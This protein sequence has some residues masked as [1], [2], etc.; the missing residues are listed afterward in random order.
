MQLQELNW[1]GADL[2]GLMARQNREATIGK[3]GVASPFVSGRVPPGF[4]LRHA[5]RYGA[6]IL[7]EY[8][9]DD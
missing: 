4:A 1:D 2:D 5:A 9:R 6:D 3:D 7:Q 8:E